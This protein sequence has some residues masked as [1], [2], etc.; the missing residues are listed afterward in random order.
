MLFRSAWQ[1]LFVAGAYFGYRKAVGRPS[2]IPA[3]R[4][5]FV[6]SI[7]LVTLLFLVRHQT[8][9]LGNLNLVDT[10]A[11]LGAWRSINHPLRLINFAAFAYILWYLPRSVDE[12]LHGLSALRWLRYL[13][14]HSLQVFAWSVLVSYTASSFRVSWVSLS[15][16]WQALLAIAVA[17][18]L[19]IPAWMHER[20]RL[21]REK[22]L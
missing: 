15:P 17:L 10:Q 7:V 8:L 13:G 21:Q 16:A 2:A 9:F 3:S 12:K 4:V 20:W 19:A 6:F 1:L 14:G 5:L 22:S 18:S 11:A